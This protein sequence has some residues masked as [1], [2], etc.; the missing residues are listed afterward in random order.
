M[1]VLTMRQECVERFLNGVTDREIRSWKT[2]YRGE[3][4]LHCSQKNSGEMGG[5]IVAK[6]KLTK[7]IYNFESERYE[8]KLEEIKPLS[9]WIAAKGK[10]GLWTFE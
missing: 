8:W 6:C 7:M 1:K 3:L 5:Y 9:K 2:N 10:L 4:Y